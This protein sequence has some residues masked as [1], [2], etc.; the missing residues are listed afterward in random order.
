MLCGVPVDAGYANAA[1]D[2][3]V[4]VPPRDKGCEPLGLFANDEFADDLLTDVLLNQ[5]GGLHLDLGA[6]LLFRDILQLYFF[7][8]RNDR[9]EPGLTD[10]VEDVGMSI[11]HKCKL[12]AQLTVGKRLLADIGAAPK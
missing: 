4:K 8:E 6:L 10:R 5:L 1:P 7:T 3:R 11:A 9:V 2:L 12:L